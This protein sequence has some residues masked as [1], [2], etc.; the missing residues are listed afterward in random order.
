MKAEI[1]T[2]GDELLIGQVVNTNAAFLARAMNTIGIHVERMNT[3]SDDPSDIIAYLNEASDRADLVIST[4]GLG[5]TRD[6]TTK[7]AYC[8]F[9]ED[10]LIRNP[11]VL[12]HIEHLFEKYIS[13]PIS[14][15]NRLQ[16][17]VPSKARILHNPYGTAPGMWMEKNDRVYVAL[18]G[19]PYEMQ[20]LVETEVLPRLRE[21][22]RMPAIVHRTLLTYGLGESAIADR[23]EALEDS[24]PSHIKLAYLPNAGKVRLRLS[25]RGEDADILQREVEAIVAELY[26]RIGDI[27][28]GEEGK[29][30]LP[31]RI[32]GLLKA[33]GWRMA[34]AESLTG[35][36]IAS[37]LVA[38]SGA[39]DFFQG[40][41]VAYA[42]DI[43][44]NLLGVSPGTIDRYTV[45]SEQVAREMAQSA[46]EKFRSEVAVSVTGVAGPDPGESGQPVGTVWIGVHSPLRTHAEV[47]SFGN[48]RE[49][50]TQKTLNKAL[51]L[52]YRELQKNEV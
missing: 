31:V 20:N 22:F 30:D 1:L 23:I 28:V 15:R 25:G 35:G 6:D 26:T 46:A 41:A 51:E 14:E 38:Q 13:T 5:P 48:H 4:G 16:A 45:V 3:L 24:L 49:R 7:E 36:R 47:F 34:T 8:R 17:M 29:E 32:G 2:I 9:T 33:K 21:R 44:T 19:V 52:L 10:T 42:T 11:E 40:G 39:S 43:K 27:I 50:I 12:A 37:T 18:P